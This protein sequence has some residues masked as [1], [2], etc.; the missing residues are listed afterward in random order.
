MQ[1]PKPNK[2]TKYHSIFRKDA[3]LKHN[4]LYSALAIASVLKRVYAEPY[5]AIGACRQ[6]GSGGILVLLC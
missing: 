3:Q 5:I 4:R 6:A 1:S 2:K